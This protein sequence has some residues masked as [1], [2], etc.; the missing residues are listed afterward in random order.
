MKN[1]AYIFLLLLCFT[2]CKQESTEK[3]QAVESKT[4]TQEESLQKEE[5][6]EWARTR[7][8][9]YYYTGAL[10]MSEEYDESL[11][12]LGSIDEYDMAVTPV[13]IHA[14]HQSED[15][16]KVNF[17]GKEK[18]VSAGQ[19]GFP[20]KVQKAKNYA[21]IQTDSYGKAY[22]TSYLYLQGEDG[23][24][25]SIF[26]NPMDEEESEEPAC[27]FLTY[28]EGYENKINSIEEKDDALWITIEQKMENVIETN[29]YHIYKEDESWWADR[30]NSEMVESVISIAEQSIE[31]VEDLALDKHLKAWNTDSGRA[32]VELVGEYIDYAKQV[33]KNH[34]ESM[35]HPFR[36][37]VGDRALETATSEDKKL[38]FYSF[39]KETGGTMQFYD[40]VY[41]TNENGTVKTIDVKEGEGDNGYYVSDIYTFDAEK[42]TYYVVIANQIASNRDIVQIA[43]AYTLNGG[44]LQP[45]KLFTTEKKDYDEIPV[46]YDFFSAMDG[47]DERPIRVIRYDYDTEQLLVAMVDQ[48]GNVGDKNLIYQWTGNE[49]KYK[50]VK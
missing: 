50:G 43:R 49:F 23:T 45:V 29:T 47:R 40:T 36:Q 17:K 16:V 13:E 42:E 27:L 8:D 44:E 15:F 28:G 11:E 18:I 1:F 6:P 32:D 46:H 3:E 37:L 19:V 35:T 34:P 25:Y 21:I 20:I 10:D 38:R 7:R 24:L 39:N 33:I 2:A 4:E 26:E 9:A 12:S 14:V 22:R 5:Q 48:D 41:Q 31:K 30:T